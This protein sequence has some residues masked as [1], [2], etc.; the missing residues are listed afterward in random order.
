MKAALIFLIIVLIGAI[1]VGSYAWLFNDGVVPGTTINI[2]PPPQPTAAEQKLIDLSLAALE[3]MSQLDD[4]LAAEVAA[5]HAVV[6]IPKV[7]RAGFIFGGGGGSGAVFLKERPIGTVR[8]SGA[9]VG[10]QIGAQS[11][12]Q[13]ILVENAAR[14]TQLRTGDT[15]ATVQA[16][17]VAAEAGAAASARYTDGIKIIIGDAKGLMAE[18]A[19]G[20]QKLSYF[21]LGTRDPNAEEKAAAEKTAVDDEKDD[22]KDDS[23]PPAK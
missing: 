19:V 8:V 6:V 23:A 11:F 12:T 4:S 14:L 15:K 7:G 16:T 21:E 22:D 18:A 3:E 17:A 5:A 1:G 2:T 20:A 9:T 10:F 13:L